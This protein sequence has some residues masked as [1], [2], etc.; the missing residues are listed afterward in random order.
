MKRRRWLLFKRSSKFSFFA[1]TIVF[2]LSFARHWWLSE[3]KVAIL[4]LYKFAIPTV[5]L[6]RNLNLNTKFVGQELDMPSNYGT[7]TLRRRLR[8]RL[9]CVCLIRCCDISNHVMVPPLT[10]RWGRSY[11]LH[12]S[13]I[14]STY[15]S[16]FQIFFNMPSPLVKRTETI[17]DGIRLFHFV[18]VKCSTFASLLP[19][20]SHRCR[21]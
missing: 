3:E 9:A 20:S 16:S 10:L 4:R 5:A 6:H 12:S 2:R 1:Y 21:C 7:W 18:P 14:L 13:P 8:W 19:S 11:P 17:L 15:L